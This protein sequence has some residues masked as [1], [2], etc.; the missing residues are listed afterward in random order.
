MHL[1][2]ETATRAGSVAIVAPDGLSAWRSL[3]EQTGHARDLLVIVESLL[4]DEGRAARDLHGIGV[5]TGPGSFTG[6]RVGMATAKGLAYALDI[7]VEG[8]STLEALAREAAAAAALLCPVLDAGRG[9]VYAAIFER[10]EDGGV[11]RRSEDR[12]WKPGDLAAHLP[13]GVVLVGDGA[14]AVS[15]RAG[16]GPAILPAPPSI[17]RSIAAWAAESIPAGTRFRP[18]TLAP[19]YIR[20]SD[21]ESARRR[22]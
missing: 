12:A 15:E 21:A 11:M 10:G 7:P 8:L 3:P 22:T 19:N 5:A 6:A 2:I 16:G 20:P 13:A 17:A 18:G 14:R 9:E 4:R 1:G